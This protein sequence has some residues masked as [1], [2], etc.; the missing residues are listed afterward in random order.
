[1]HKI[2]II[3]YASEMKKLGILLLVIVTTIAA[4]GVGLLRASDTVKAPDAEWALGSDTGQA[5]Q[6]LLVSQEAAAARILKATETNP[7][8]RL[9]GMDMLADLL[10]VALEM[11]VDKGDPLRP[12]FTDWMGDYRKV[13]GDVGDAI[14]HTAELDPRHSYVIS[15]NIGEVNYMGFQLYGLNPVNGWNRATENINTHDMVIAENGDFTL[16]LSPDSATTGSNTLPI[17]NNVHM[18][19]DVHMV[20]VRQYFFDR[21]NRDAAKFSI[22]RIAGD[23]TTPRRSAE[24]DA[25][26][27]TKIRAATALFNGVVDGVFAMQAMLATAPN[28][29]DPP[30]RYDPDFAGIFYPTVDNE[31]FGTWFHIAPH[32]A[33]IIE[34]KVPSFK[35]GASGYWSI[36]LQNRWM[37]SLDYV[38]RQTSLNSRDLIVKEDGTYRMI[39][40]HSEHFEAGQPNATIKALMGATGNWLETDGHQEGLLAIR[41][42]LAE[43]FE[44]PA[45]RMVTLE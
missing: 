8:V 30:R 1:M 35:D 42:Q 3:P 38:D 33:L 20:M 6:E 11:K 4:Y 40:A 7:Q 12:A 24:T 37:Q 5:W 34:G 15:G 25:L 36:S 10:S 9:E 2:N 27:A 21:P 16:T 13:F 26:R 32:E 29:P 31:Y 43:S 28:R 22:R 14:Y 19:D 17:S 41:Y 39:I 23:G 44:R 18:S 45:I